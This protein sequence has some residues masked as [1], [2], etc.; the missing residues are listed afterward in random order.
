MELIKKL[1][2][3]AFTLKADLATVI[4]DVIIHFFV[5]FGIYI[6]G[7]LMLS[8]GVFGLVIYVIS[9]IAIVYV[10]LSA[11]MSLLHYFKVIK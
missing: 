4:V 10:I 9:R 8:L 5:G 6:L 3:M 11:I 2:P 7:D 1:F